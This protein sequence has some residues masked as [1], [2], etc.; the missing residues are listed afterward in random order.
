MA[1]NQRTTTLNNGIE[2][3]LVGLGAY[4][5]H[6]KEAE[7]AI[8]DATGN[9]ATGLLIQHRCIVTKPKLA[10]RSASSGTAA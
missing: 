3:P 1:F 4:D 9:Q 7:Q 5:M 2:M 10:M 8:L 6:G